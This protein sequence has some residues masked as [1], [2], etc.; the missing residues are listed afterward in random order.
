MICFHKL[1]LNFMNKLGI[2]CKNCNPCA[3]LS[4]YGGAGT[5]SDGKPIIQSLKNGRRSE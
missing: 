4:G 5:F 2:P 1:F 3:I